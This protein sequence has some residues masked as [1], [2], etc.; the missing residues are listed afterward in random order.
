MGSLGM[1][2]RRKR[3]MLVVVAV[4]FYIHLK[5]D[6]ESSFQDY[7]VCYKQAFILIFWGKTSVKHLTGLHHFWF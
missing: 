5:R 2:D 3:K 6:E 7:Y 1:L 4:V